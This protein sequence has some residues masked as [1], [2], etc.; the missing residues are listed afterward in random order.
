MNE[1]TVEDAALAWPKAFGWQVAHGPNIAPDQPR[2][3][4]RNFSEVALAQRLRDAL[5]LQLLSGKQRVEY[6]EACLR[7]QTL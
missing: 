7:E 6:A 5:L 2:A 3:V 1:S 4:R